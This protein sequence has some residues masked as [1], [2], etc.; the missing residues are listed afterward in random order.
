MVLWARTLTASECHQMANQHPLLKLDH[1]SNVKPPDTLRITSLTS[2][3]DLPFPPVLFRGSQRSRK[4]QQP[5]CIQVKQ[6]QTPAKVSSQADLFM[7]E[8]KKEEM[9]EMENL[10]RKLDQLKNGST[11]KTRW[12]NT[13]I[14]LEG[15]TRKRGQLTGTDCCI[16]A[17]IFSCNLLF[18]Q[19]LHP[20]SHGTQC[21]MLGNDR[22]F[23][24][25]F[26]TVSHALVKHEERS[27]RIS[28]VPEAEVETQLW[29]FNVFPYPW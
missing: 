28:V 14:I 10:L 7:N 1:D 11:A 2:I 16:I 8:K 20:Y 3:T 4:E 18:Y 21:Y 22:L 29:R 6:M 27:H 5:Q 15:G 9:V 12:W 23:P 24:K 19:A 25:T 26:R 17:T 13:S